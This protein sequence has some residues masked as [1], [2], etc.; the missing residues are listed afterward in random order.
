[1]ATRFAPPRAGALGR[2]L[3]NSLLRHEWLIAVATIRSLTRSVKDFLA[4]ALVA[5]FAFLAFREGLAQFDAHT[6]EIVVVALASVLATLV[7][8]GIRGR[9]GFF[10]R[11]SPISAA[12]QV[13]RNR[14]VYR[15]SLHLVAS[16][17]Y[18]ALIASPDLT[19]FG[20]AMASWWLTL[21][22]IQLV[23]VAAAQISERVGPTRGVSVWRIFRSR[24][25][26]AGFHIACLPGAVAVALC[27]FFDRFPQAPFIAGL[28]TF[29]GLYWYAPIDHQVVNFER[30]AGFS[31]LR[32][33]RARLTASAAMSAFYIAAAA[34]STSISTLAAV[35]GVATC[36][37]AYDAL[38]VLLSRVLRARQVQ[39][40]MMLIL[41]AVLSIGLA[42]PIVVP[43]FLLGM[44]LWLNRKAGKATWLLR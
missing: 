7:D 15:F 36:L 16:T 44:A 23:A 32:S 30:I 31:P 37:L 5:A 1:M 33:I 2:I 17:G 42:L 20:E 21:V 29:T 6:R 27:G 18:A 35:A 3:A 39:F 10:V 24:H 8:I 13:G 14:T 4:L 25:S 41:F 38:M 28:V 9:L 26:R 22:P 43:A 11:E 40:A 19:G 34:L 12:A